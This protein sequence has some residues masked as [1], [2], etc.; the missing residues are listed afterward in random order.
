MKHLLLAL[1]F[2]VTGLSGCQPI[3]KAV[4]GVNREF[5]F[6]TRTDYLAFMNRTYSLAPEQ[7]VYFDSVSERL[8]ITDAMQKSI[9]EYYG[10]FI[11][12][13]TEI[14][15]SAFLEENASCIGRVLKEIED[16][17][18]K[19]D[20]SLLVKNTV[21]RNYKLLNAKTDQQLEVNADKKVK[22]FLLYSYR[23]GTYFNSFYKDVAALSKNNKDQLSIY[24]ITVDPI[25]GLPE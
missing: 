14:K 8:F 6:T 12:D 18:G 13:S 21:F 4:Y 5:R 15:Q 9:S 23:L 1:L 19:I 25:R 24:V 2:A 10:S 3:L 16:N 20:D 11:N 7:I 22:V 17:S